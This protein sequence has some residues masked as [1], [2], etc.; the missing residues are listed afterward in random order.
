[1]KTIK[2]I[3]GQLCICTPVSLSQKINELELKPFTVKVEAILQAIT[4]R[5]HHCMA[6]LE[7]NIAKDLVVEHV[8]FHT[9]GEKEV[10]VVRYANGGCFNQPSYEAMEQIVTTFNELSCMTSS[11]DVDFLQTLSILQLNQIKKALAAFYGTW[12]NTCSFIEEIEGCKIS[13]QMRG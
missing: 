12:N 10:S 13:Q 9:D 7:E 3:N 6:E 11:V 1:M 2:T 5:M 8:V 4:Q